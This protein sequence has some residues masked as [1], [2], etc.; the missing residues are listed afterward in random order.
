M[1]KNN[2]ITIQIHYQCTESPHFPLGGKLG[3][4]SKTTRELQGSIFLA[5]LSLRIH[6]YLYSCVAV[7]GNSSK[8]RF[9]VYSVHF[10]RWDTTPLPSM[11]QFSITFHVQQVT[12]SCTVIARVLEPEPG[13]LAEAGAV[14]FPR[15]RL[16]LQLQL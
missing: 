12:T 14:S 15:L 6:S 2:K 7:Y 10:W 8:K 5:E 4:L 13:Y 16:Q 9:Q 3:Q 1:H 11:I